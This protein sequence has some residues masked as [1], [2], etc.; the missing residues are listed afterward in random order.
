[1]GFDIS[2][3]RNQLKWLVKFFYGGLINNC[4]EVFIRSKG[5][6]SV[7]HLDG[8][9]AIAVL[10]VTTFHML[11]G[12]SNP[13]SFTLPTRYYFHYLKTWYFYPAMNGT[14]G[15]DLFLI[16]AGYLVG[17]MIL[18]D[19]RQ[20]GQ[21]QILRFYWRRF[22]RI[23]PALAVSL[24]VCDRVLNGP[25]MNIDCSEWWWKN[26]IFGQNIW[27][28]QMDDDTCNAHTWT[29]SLE[30]QFYIISPIFMVF[31]VPLMQKRQAIPRILGFFGILMV[32]SILII[33][34]LELHY[35]SIDSEVQYYIL[36]DLAI[37]YTKPYTR[38][39][40]FFAG[41]AAVTVLHVL[42]RCEL[43][44]AF[45]DCPEWTG[46][47]KF[48]CDALAATSIGFVGLWLGDG[49]GYHGEPY[50]EVY[51]LMLI[52]FS[53]TVLSI[54]VAY[55]IVTMSVGQHRTLNA[56][57]S[58]KVWIPI[59]RL[60]YSAYL[61]QYIA[62]DWVWDEYKYLNTEDESETLTKT[63]WMLLMV[64]PLIN[65]LAFLSFV[66]VEMPCMKARNLF[67]RTGHSQLNG[68]GGGGGSRMRR[69]EDATGG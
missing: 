55:F 28:P 22:M 60:S 5:N 3:E 10:W 44:P 63:I 30:V 24:V 68:G 17:Q 27:G 42:P 59:A 8:L 56:F 53:R 66:L 40:A 41:L 34:V 9:R 48:C 64:F 1:M 58:M 19:Y 47:R 36:H 49:G 37:V 50:S 52:L 16:L 39:N 65:L 61:L 32:I 20:T 11:L 25:K 54:A 12:W 46:P 14:F 33:L 31:L 18:K 67:E 43:N 57:L 26:L 23:W 51:N 38:V 6:Q 15:V 7:A 62:A 21:L 2:P 45:R 13:Y 35:A 69:D 4:K 29:V